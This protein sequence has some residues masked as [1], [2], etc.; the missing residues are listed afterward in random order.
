MA[1]GFEEKG[2]QFIETDPGSKAGKEG[3]K[4]VWEAVKKA[5]SNRT[6]IAYWGYP[7]FSKTGE[8]RKEPDIFIVDKELGLMIIEVKSIAIN[9]LTKVDGHSWHFQ[10]LY[11]P[12]GNPY[13]QAENQLYAILGYCDKEPEIRRKI[14][15]R[16]L[17]ALP[18]ITE[19]Q[20]QENRVS[21]SQTLLTSGLA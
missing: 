1:V 3:E 9:Q 14:R 16:S 17:V 7:I 20:W 12:N 4:K 5:F 15:G 8:S 10:N 18:L 11:V 2:R 6:C 19:E 13:Q 21:A